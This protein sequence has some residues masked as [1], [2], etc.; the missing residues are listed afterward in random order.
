MKT[1]KG[2][3]IPAQPLH[4]MNESQNLYRATFTNKM[5]WEQNKT[6]SY[7]E[8]VTSIPNASRFAQSEFLKATN[9][10]DDQNR[11]GNNHKHKLRQ[12]DELYNQRRPIPM[13]N[14]YIKPQDTNLWFHNNKLHTFASQVNYNA[15]FESGNFL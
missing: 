9:Q 10:P 11:Q 12:V 3:V 4:L 5:G 15:H 1:A 14:P 7:L 8:T 6:K 2:V 13:G